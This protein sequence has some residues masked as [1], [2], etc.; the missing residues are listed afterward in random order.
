LGRTG[1]LFACE[2]E[3]VVPDL[4]CIGKALAGGVPLAATVGRPAVMDAWPKST[5]EALHTATFAG[6]PLACAAALATLDELIRLNLTARAHDGAAA[7]AGRLE[8]LL[9]YPHA[10]AVRG[11]GYLQAVEFATAAVANTIV[12]DAL[13]RGVILLQSGPT[14]TSITFA[15]PLVIA[16]D[17]LARALDLVESVVAGVE[18]RS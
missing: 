6:N 9:K 12:V 10:A 5:G 2:R 15:P 3:G 8:R 18:R 11:I 16:D 7:F 4:L 13:A 1:T 17:Q 14:G